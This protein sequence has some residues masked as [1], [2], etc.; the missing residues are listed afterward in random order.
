MPTFKLLGLEIFIPDLRDLANAVVKPLQNALTG[1]WNGLNRSIQGMWSQLSAGIN[2][3]GAQLGAGINAL[4]TQLGQWGAQ[5]SAGINQ[6]GAQLGAG[7]N[8]LGS[9]LS[10]GISGF[11]QAIANGISGIFTGITQALDPVQWFNSLQNF[12][13]GLGERLMAILT[14]HSP[15]EPERAAKE[16]QDLLFW[17]NIAFGVA[18]VATIVAELATLGQVDNTLSGIF[19]L[20]IVSAYKAAIEEATKSELEAS[21]FVPLRYYYN[22]QHTPNIPSASDLVRFVV[23]ECFPLEK[24]PPAPP[25]FVKYMQYQGYKEEWS[26]AFWEAH[27]QLPSPDQ[28]YEA[29][30][31]GIIT[32]QEL[33]KYIIWHDYKPTKRPGI[34]KSDVDIMLQLTYRWP[35]RTEAR[36][37]FSMGLLGEEDLERIARAEGIAPEFLQQFVRFMSEFEL[38]D[39]FRRLERE[40]RQLFIQQKIDESKYREYLTEARVPAKWHDLFVKLARMEAARKAREDREKARDLTYSQ[41][42]Y[43]F[44]EGIISREFF[45]EKLVE[46]GYPQEDINVLI[47]VE[48]AKRYNTIRSRIRTAV[49]DAFVDGKISERDA[50]HYLLQAGHTQDEISMLLQVARLEALPRRRTLTPT[51]VARAAWKGL[52]DLNSALEYLLRLGYEKEDAIIL[53][54]L[55]RPTQKE[56]GEAS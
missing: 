35:T 7:I 47:A 17:G 27:W 20:P 4:G 3:L 52:L 26:K 40:A 12:F 39:D 36:M 38:R 53:L 29:F 6:L 19:D 55:Y 16:A 15:K 18:T 51:Q 23:R 54:L 22:K 21:L 33:R 8:A 10:A 24:L 46:L 31:R 45:R 56:E 30:H 32:E 41:L 2:Q 11:G 48:E 28:L 14:P 34:S 44:R 1:V 43:A 9:Q 13:G 50:I 5:L 25:E 37:M 42:A 49:L